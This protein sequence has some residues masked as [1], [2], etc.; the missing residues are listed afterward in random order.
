LFDEVVIHGLLPRVI[1]GWGVNHAKSRSTPGVQTP[2]KFRF[3][4]L[5]VP[6]IPILAK[7]DPELRHC[8]GKHFKYAADHVAD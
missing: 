4:L 2:E 1:K 5:S 6:C 7:E 8:D 3:F